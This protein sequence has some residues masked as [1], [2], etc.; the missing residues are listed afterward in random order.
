MNHEFL[1]N[2]FVQ[3]S[4]EISSLMGLESTCYLLVIYFSCLGKGFGKHLKVMRDRTSSF[5]LFLRR[6][7]VLLL[8]TYVFKNLAI[9]SLWETSRVETRYCLSSG[10]RDHTLREAY[11]SVFTL[12]FLI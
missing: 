5:D 12:R 2:H 9:D 11:K 1:R 7:I 6:N 3:S 10:T 4:H 8:F